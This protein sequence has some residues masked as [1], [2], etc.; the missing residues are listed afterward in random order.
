MRKNQNI[1]S[2]LKAL[3]IVVCVWF[4]NACTPPPVEEP[5]EYPITTAVPWLMFDWTYSE[6]SFEVESEVSFVAH[7]DADWLILGET[8]F[9]AGRQILTVAALEN[10]EEEVREAN[11]TLYPMDEEPFVIP[12]S[13]FPN[14]AGEKFEIVT[15]SLSLDSFEQTAWIEVNC[16]SPIKV[17]TA[18]DWIELDDKKV[19]G[20][21]EEVVIPIVVKR[22]MTKADRS[23]KV[24]V[25]T[26]DDR[27]WKDVVVRQS[28]YEPVMTVSVD[29][30]TNDGNQ[31]VVSFEVVSELDFEVWA[32]DEWAKPKVDGVLKADAKHTIEVEL[33]RNMSELPR[34]TTIHIH[35]TMGGLLREEVVITQGPKI[36]LRDNEITQISLLRRFNPTLK[37]DYILKPDKDGVFSCYIPGEMG[38]PYVDAEGTTFPTFYPLDIENMVITFET[39]APRVY[40]GNEQLVSGESVCDLSNITT[41]KAVAESGDIR[42]YTID[43]EYFTGLPIVYIDLD[44]GNEVASRDN[45]EA[46]SIHIVGAD[47]FEGLEEQRF[48][49]HGR[50][51]SSWGTVR[52][53]PS[54]TFK[55][56]SAQ[57]V[58][59]MPAHKKWVM[60]G[61]YR[62]KTLLRNSVAWWLSERMSI[63]SWTPR[64]RQVEV[65]LNGTYRGVYQLTEQVRIGKDR[66]NIAEMLPTDTKGEAITGGY[67]VE[68]HYGSDGDQ[69]GWDMPV[70]QGNSG[71]AVKVPKKEDSNE[72]QRDYIMNYVLNID[73]MFGEVRKGGDPTE[74]MQYIDIPSWVAQ[75]LVF[76]ISGTTEPQGPNSW[77][78]YK[79]R[80]DDKWY[81][82]PAW[83]F[84]YR[85]Y[86]PATASGWVNN[87]TMYLPEMLRYRPFEQEMVRQW[88][89]V[90]EP[91]LPDLLQY[92]EEQ[93]VYLRRSA[94]ENWSLHE[95]NLLTDGR[96]EN[97]DEQ[98]PWDDALDRMIN[99]L[100]LKWAFM[101]RN[102]GN[103]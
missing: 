53:K 32:D 37:K 5:D 1:I 64:Y 102:I 34:Q 2:A 39:T 101:S 66:L 42:E 41:I 100:N 65:I 6:Q 35:T 77:Y 24:S 16:G 43:V 93:R 87:N 48:M 76:E 28:K 15:T 96:H 86:I 62:D 89:E 38:G 22:N 71:A 4:A 103:M 13:Q 33:E 26:A 68:F 59:G 57:E 50:G 44:T 82:G 79:Q 61:N 81:C 46:G 9:E 52:K 55:L 99:Y 7:S 40:V 78:T 10:P 49:I 14:E 36:A 51:N 56:D 11:L 54:Y 47:D 75:W 73:K 95:P 98:I 84:D 72:A 83:D 67:I 29:S 94:E 69:W 63:L 30:L 88:R 12:V 58:L 91:L 74:V 3:M 80:G 21:G 25:T 31:G 70:L 8:E 60:I 85:S 27:K 92:I 45:Y 97:G 90:V 18:A 23:A 19:Y 17:L 20:P